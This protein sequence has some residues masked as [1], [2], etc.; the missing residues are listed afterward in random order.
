[1]KTIKFNISCLFIYT[2]H[3]LGSFWPCAYDIRVVSALLKDICM[4]IMSILIV[5]VA[6]PKIASLLIESSC[7]PSMTVFTR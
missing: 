2:L 4:D 6:K 5:T 7:W 1:M 3:S